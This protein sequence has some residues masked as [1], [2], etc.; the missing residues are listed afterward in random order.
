MKNTNNDVDEYKDVPRY[1][2]T[3][4]CPRCQ[5]KLRIWVRDGWI[6][7]EDVRSG[8]GEIAYVEC[9]CDFNQEAKADWLE[10]AVRRLLN[11]LNPR[12]DERRFVISKDK[13]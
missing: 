7:D 12:F 8:G 1:G 9:E 4:Y 13:E 10:E 5:R 2:G 6:K 3:T 11:K